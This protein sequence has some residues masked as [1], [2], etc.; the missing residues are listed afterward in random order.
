MFGGRDASKDYYFR[1]C[2]NY[3]NI[4]IKFYYTSSTLSAGLG[5]HILIGRYQA[6]YLVL[7]QRGCS[8]ACDVMI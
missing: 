1:L 2:I 7:T 5:F 4:I 3:Y 8:T 6:P